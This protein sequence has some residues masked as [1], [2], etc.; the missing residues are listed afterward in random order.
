MPLN[1]SQLNLR[2]RQASVE[3]AHG[4]FGFPGAA[5]E[6]IA[7]LVETFLEIFGRY[8][9]IGSQQK[10]LQIADG[11]RREIIHRGKTKSLTG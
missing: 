7:E 11:D 2:V 10:S 4:K 3:Q 5:I 9:V 6:A 1:H 8:A